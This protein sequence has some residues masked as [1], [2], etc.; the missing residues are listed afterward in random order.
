MKT[1]RINRECS[2]LPALLQ[3]GHFRVRVACRAEFLVECREERGA[4]DAAWARWVP[5][6][7]DR[8]RVRACLEDAPRAMGQATRAPAEVQRDQVPGACRVVAGRPPAAASEAAWGSR[9]L[10]VQVPLRAPDTDTGR[11]PE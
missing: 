9:G 5:D 6:N 3:E 10:A 8:D 4:P 2:A 7:S 11:V 1:T